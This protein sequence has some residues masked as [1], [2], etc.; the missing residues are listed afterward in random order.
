MG[1]DRH[2]VPGEFY[3]VDDRTGFPQR[4]R[5]MRKEWTN[6]IVDK[7]RWEA[8]HPQDFVRGVVDDQTVPEPRPRQ[9]DT[10]L[11]VLSTTLTASANAG[12][13]GLLVASST[14]MLIGDVVEIMLDTGNYFRSTIGSV[15]TLNSIN[16]ANPLPY[17]AAAGNIVTDLSAVATANIG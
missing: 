15:P 11:G 2:Y 3:Q 6:A 14:R 8:R 9:T 5:R 12:A 13:L 4:S 17:S 7:N 10:F 16:I 1:T